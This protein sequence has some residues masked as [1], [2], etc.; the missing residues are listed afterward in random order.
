MARLAL[1][2]GTLQRESGRLRVYQRLLPVLDMKKRQ[3]MAE[4]RSAQAALAATRARMDDQREQVARTLPMLANRKIDLQGLVRVTAARVESGNRLGVRI[5]VL[6]EVGTK[7]ADYG[8]LIRPHWVDAV[9][10]AVDTLVRLRLQEEVDAEV[11]RRLGQAV[12]KLTQRVN[13]FEKVLIPRTRGNIRRIRIHLAD[14]ERA[15]VVRAKIAKRKR[16]GA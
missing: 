14:A 10:E 5:P 3:L 11:V 8:R 9:A 7:R 4:H 15:A 1:N 16:L 12:N 13:L 2:K 6:G